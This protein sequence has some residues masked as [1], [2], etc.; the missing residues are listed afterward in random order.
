MKLHPIDDVRVLGLL[1]S[2]SLVL[3]IGLSWIPSLEHSYRV[4]GL[5]GFLVGCGF[6][7]NLYAFILRKRQRSA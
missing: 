4:H 7:L 6:S 3:G 1:G 5:V 2:L